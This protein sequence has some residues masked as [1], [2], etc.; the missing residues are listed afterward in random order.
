MYSEKEK[1]DM[2]KLAREAIE[3]AY[4]GESPK[5]PEGLSEKRGVFVTIKKN[6]KLRGCIGFPDAIYPLKEAI[7]KAA[8]AAAFNDPRFPPLKEEELKDVEIEISILTPKEEIAPDPQ[9]VTIGKHG[10]IVEY[11]L[12]SGLLLPQVA[13]E[14]GW[15]AEEFLNQVCIKAGMP[16]FAWKHMPIKLYR[17]E[18]EVFNE[19]QL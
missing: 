14:Q 19:T 4:K 9:N 6:N 15:D 5:L 13:V 12:L 17:F 18:A 3:T 1:Q 10:L 8:R 11:G 2:L 16:P 7:A